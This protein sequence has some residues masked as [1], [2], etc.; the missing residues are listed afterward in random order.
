LPSFLL[1]YV[2]LKKDRQIVLNPTRYR[3]GN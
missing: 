2:P 3:I 1:G